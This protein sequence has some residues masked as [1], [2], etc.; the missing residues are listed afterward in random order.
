MVIKSEN[1][2]CNNCG[3]KC[4]RHAKGMCTTCYKKLFWKPKSK[5]CI[6]CKRI[7]P[8]HAKGYC[9]GCYNTLFHLEKTKAHNYKKW[10]NIDYLLYKKIT[11]QCII[12]EFKKIV[13]LHHLD[14]NKKNNSESNLV[15]LCPNHH[16]M[17]HRINFRKEVI[18]E[19][20]KKFKE[21]GLPLFEDKSE[22]F[23]QNN[24]RR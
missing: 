11:E 22:V 21:K 8:L 23:I 4:I 2:L 24:N 9:N 12:C 20:N 16:K 15:G 7:L 14:K 6:R 10:H 19:L 18:D 17:F 5:E 1:Q 3:K 13:E